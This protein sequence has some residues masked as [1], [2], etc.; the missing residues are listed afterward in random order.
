[1]KQSPC[2]KTPELGRGDK[3]MSLSVD[4]RPMLAARPAADPNAARLLEM[5][6]NADEVLNGRSPVQIGDVGMPRLAQVPSKSLSEYLVQH[7]LS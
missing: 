6:R 5:F 4:V 1:M 3:T 7:Q 2:S